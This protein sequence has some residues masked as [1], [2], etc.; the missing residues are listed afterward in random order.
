MVSLAKGIMVRVVNTAMNVLSLLLVGVGFA[1]MATFFVGS[2]FGS[3]A[4]ASGPVA[5]PARGAAAPEQ[6]PPQAA[7]VEEQARSAQQQIRRLGADKDRPAAGK[8]APAKPAA[9]GPEDKRLWLTVPKMGRVED[10]LIPYTVG[11]DE[12]KLREYTAIHLKGSGFPWVKGSNVYIAGHRIGYFGTDSLFAF[13]DLDALE[14]GDEVYLRD[15]TGKRYVYRVFRELI[16]APTEVSVMRPVSGKSILTLQTC[17]LPDYSQRLIVQ[18][19]RV[20]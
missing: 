14:N 4:Q 20:A 15:S 16:V 13:Y 17:T 11:S 10:D 9:V 1:L 2:P 18:A 19:E 5:A 7:G 3:S 6:A 12:G 8:A